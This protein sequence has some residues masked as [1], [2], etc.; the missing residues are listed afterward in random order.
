MTT[1]EIPPEDPYA[2]TAPDPLALL[3]QSVVG[4]AMAFPHAIPEL[5]HEVAAGDFNDPRL[6]AIFRGVCDEHA[7]GRPVDYLSISDLLPRWNIGTIDLRDLARW[8]SEAYDPGI[9][10]H[11]ARMVR[12]ASIRRLMARVGRELQAPDGDVGIALQRAIEQLHTIGSIGGGTEEPVRW[13]RDVLDVPES[14]DAYDWVIPELLERRDR[15]MLT[16]IEGGGKSTFTRQIAVM[17]AAGI[18]PTKFYGIDPI[19]VLVIDAENSERQWRRSVRP[20]VAAAVAQGSSDP[21]DRI[22]VHCVDVMDIT[23]PDT[24]AR[25]H[26]WI[27]EVKPDLLLLGPLYRVTRGSLNDDDAVAPVLHALD[28]IRARDIA[29]LIE[30][31]AG[32][33]RGERG[34]RDLRP[35]GSSALLGWPEFGLGIRAE[36]ELRD[37]ARKV[38]TLIRWRGDRDRREWPKRLAHGQL[39]PWEPTF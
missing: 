4:T 33:A 15:L 36:K 28:G 13:L 32:H 10:A 22:A 9:G 39:W 34:E 26:R 3:E 8:S 37:G 18:H 7:E 6:G 20:M 24:Q 31:H 38:S 11:H 35:R 12:A 16:G 17:G 14:E 27:D 25:I 21:R 1:D 23:Q 5:M 30:L 29:M 19:R 2:P